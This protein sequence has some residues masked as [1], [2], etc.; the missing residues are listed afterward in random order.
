MDKAAQKPRYHALDALR[1]LSILLMIA[2]HFAIDLTAYGMVP[3]WLLDNVIIDVAQPFFASCFIALSGASSRF[4][5]SN[6]RRGVKILICAALVTLATWGMTQVSGMQVTVVFGILHFLGVASLL[7]HVLEPLLD[8]VW[9]PGI[10]WFVLFLAARFFFPRQG[11]VPIWMAPLGVY[12][13]AFRSADYYPLLPWIFMYFF[14]VWV[15]DQVRDNRLAPAFYRFRCK[16]LEAV[17]R[18]SLWIYLLH[19]PLIML[20]FQLYFALASS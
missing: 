16:P 9:Q 7:Y 5:H 8:R 13:G 14:G 4:S 6:V 19:Q 12:P 1:G 11:A 10:T 3:D 2:H 17:S 15:A 20:G 18:H